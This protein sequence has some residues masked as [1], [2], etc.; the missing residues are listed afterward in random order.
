MTYEPLPLPAPAARRE[1]R[2]LCLLGQPKLGSARWRHLPVHTLRRMPPRTM[3][4]G[5]WSEDIFDAGLYLLEAHAV[6]PSAEVLARC[7]RHRQTNALRA[8]ARTVRAGGVTA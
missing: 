3:V 1:L 8:P 6:E 7:E 5:K 2:L 4:V